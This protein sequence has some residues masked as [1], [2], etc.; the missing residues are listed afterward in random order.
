LDAPIIKA[1]GR[2]SLSEAGWG[3]RGAFPC[4]PAVGGFFPPFP[5]D[6]RKYFLELAGAALWAKHHFPA[7][8]IVI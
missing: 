3:K 4:P 5:G 7:G 8:G 6:S 2:K 1:A